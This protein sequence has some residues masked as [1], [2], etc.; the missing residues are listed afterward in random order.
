[1]HILWREM[2]ALVDKGLVRGIGLSNCNVQLM[3][4]LLCYARIKPVVNQVELHPFQLQDDLLKFMK[5]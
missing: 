5:D 2:E 1:M 3:M 4:D